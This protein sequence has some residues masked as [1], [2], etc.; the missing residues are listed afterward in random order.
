MSNNFKFES[1]LF[2]TSIVC[3]RCLQRMNERKRI[4]TNDSTYKNNRWQKKVYA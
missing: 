4:K 2:E 1:M 3:G